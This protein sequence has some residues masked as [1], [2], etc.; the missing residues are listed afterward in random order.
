MNWVHQLLLLLLLPVP[1]L[2]TAGHLHLQFNKRDLGG[3]RDGNQQQ[4]HIRDHSNNNDHGDA[5]VKK[6]Q[7]LKLISFTPDYNIHE[8]PPTKNEKPLKV[9]FQINLRNVL[10]INEVSQICSLETTI[11]MYW[12]DPR[13][14]PNS[15]VTLYV[16]PF[17]H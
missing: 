15:S 7:E 4:H 17:P 2:G 11:R 13:Y 6:D 14:K 1:G 16:N 12:V 8:Y 9:G 10:E 3:G 5:I